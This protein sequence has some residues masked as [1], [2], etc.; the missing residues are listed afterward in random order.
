M[1]HE[2]FEQQDMEVTFSKALEIL[3]SRPADSGGGSLQNCGGGGQTHQNSLTGLRKGILQLLT[4]TFT[5]KSMKI[6]EKHTL[7]R[8]FLSA[9]T[10]KR[11]CVI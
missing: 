3:R 6:Q 4:P 5:M 9:S 8:I 1:D 11:D 2:S 7:A 10:E